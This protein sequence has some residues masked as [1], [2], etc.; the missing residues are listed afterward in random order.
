[1]GDDDLHLVA[2]G[3]EAFHG[4]HLVGLIQARNSECVQDAGL[5]TDSLDDEGFPVVLPCG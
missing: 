5:L 1:M 2:I 4:A 3:N